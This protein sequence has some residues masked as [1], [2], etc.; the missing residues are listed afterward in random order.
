MAEKRK[1]PVGDDRAKSFSISMDGK[2]LLSW[3]SDFKTRHPELVDDDS[4][5]FWEAAA[6]ELRTSKLLGY[7]KSSG[8]CWLRRFRSSKI[9]HSRSSSS[10]L[11]Q[12]S[13]IRSKMRENRILIQDLLSLLDEGGEGSFTRNF[14]AMQLRG[15]RKLTEETKVWLAKELQITVEEINSCGVNGKSEVPAV[16]P[17]IPEQPPA[18]ERTPASET[19]PEE[20]PNPDFVDLQVRKAEMGYFEGYLQAT[21]DIADGN[22]LDDTQRRVLECYLKGGDEKALMRAALKIPKAG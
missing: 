19:P 22:T 7:W 13:Y 8:L 16:S 18:V 12:V 9:Y 1:V 2:K 17:P 3:L 14:V 21:H 11:S 4:T 10:Q 6:V 5:E 15:Q 20:G